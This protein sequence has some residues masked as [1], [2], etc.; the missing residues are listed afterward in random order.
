MNNDHN[1][2]DKIL[3]SFAIPTLEEWATAA[4]AEIAGGNP[5]EKLKWKTSDELELLPFYTS[6]NAAKS[7]GDAFQISNPLTVRAWASLPMINVIDESS[8]NAQALEHLSSEAEGILFRLT[9]PQ[10]DFERLMDGISWEHCTVAFEVEAGEL[11][12]AIVTFLQSGRYDGRRIN[13]AVYAAD[14]Q[15]I[16]MLSETSLRLSGI[17][18][19]A[20]TP[21]GEI[22]DALFAGVQQIDRFIHAGESIEA[23]LGQ[24]AFQLPLGAELLVEVAKCKALRRLWRQVTTAYGAGNDDFLYLHGYSNQWINPKFQPHGN[25]LKSTIA[26]IAGICGGC[27][28]ITIVPE[29][30]NHRMMNRIARNTSH[31]LRDESHLDKIN[32]PFAGSFALETMIDEIARKSWSMFQSRL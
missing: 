6:E 27:N 5:W 24:V 19:Q 1:L 26:A 12:N 29:E 8:A 14:L 2:D 23:A 7:S 4:S 17:K 16:P 21:C 3:S 10:T 18:L 13:G 30:D 9:S 31:V 22:S 20:S 32:D 28:A 11:A 25:M 15:T